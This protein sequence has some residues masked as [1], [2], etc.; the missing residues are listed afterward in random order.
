MKNDFAIAAIILAAG[1]SE[2][3]GRFKPLLPLGPQRVVERVV[4]LFQGAGLEEILVVVGQRAPDVR[5]AVSPL[6]VHCVEN[7]DFRDG[8]FTSVLTGI[9]AL[10]PHCRA[11]FVHPVDIPLVRTQTVKRL[12]SAFNDA[13]AAVVYPSFDGK[14]G[15]PPLIQSSLA[16]RILKWDGTGGL[17][18]FLQGCDAG[19][20]ELAVADEAVMMD[21][22]TPEDY[23]RMLS[24]L[25]HE[26]L[27]STEE[28]RVLMDRLQSLPA[29]TAAH[30][31]AVAFVAR[32]L[33]AALHAAGVD[34]YVELTGAA[35]LLHDIARMEK[36]HAAAGAR[37]L[38]FHGFTRLTPIVGSHMDLDVNA[39]A[40]VDEAQVVY[41]AD[42]LVSV[43]R[44]DNL[45]QRFARKMEKYGQ[46]RQAA[47]AIDRKRTNAQCIQGKIER[48]TGLPIHAL[49]EIAGVHD[50]ET[51]CT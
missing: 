28:C 46:D 45:A 14:R 31:R 11:F 33:A 23:R 1:L 49:T 38:E 29:A 7:P 34:I 12:I 26:G 47:M 42:K 9:R 32:Q 41:L 30:C 36:D 24:R 17:Q 43:D 39:E 20:F 22:D 35:A 4:R 16:T 8:M 44:R 25:R 50:G 18:G 10:P 5:Q 48:I 40:P 19:S 13:S 37:L 27:P 3:M 6:Q 51:Q 21:L 15:H 2:R